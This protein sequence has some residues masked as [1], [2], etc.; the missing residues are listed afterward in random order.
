[1][2]RPSLGHVWLGDDA[3]LSIEQHAKIQA[4]AAEALVHVPDP[5]A[6]P[7]LIYGF[8][9]PCGLIR[10]EAAD[11]L[12]LIEI[13][14]R[15]SNPD[16]AMAACFKPA[17]DAVEANRDRLVSAA[18]DELGGPL[19]LS[20]AELLAAYPDRRAVAGLKA[21]LDNPSKDVRGKAAL[22]LGAIRDPL[23]VPVLVAMLKDPVV[24]VRDCT[25][26]ALGKTGGREA[27]D[28]AHRRP[29]Q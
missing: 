22:A 1:M 14:G 10:K 3:L 27:E 7:L 4:A 20:A 6:V 18:M 15:E 28:G 2:S 11:T 9:D 25:V 29:G 26:L 17:L 8:S 21:A 16:E 13:F 19:A 12:C 5:R 23:L 24:S